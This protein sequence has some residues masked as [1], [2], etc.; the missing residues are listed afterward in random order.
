MTLIELIYADISKQLVEAV[1]K[2]YK[3]GL[4]EVVKLNKKKILKLAEPSPLFKISYTKADKDLLANFEKEAFTVAAVLHFECEEKLKKIAKEILS[5]EHPYLQAHP[6]SSIYDLWADEAY[7]IL[8]DYIEVADAPP[9]S[10]LTTNLRTAINSSFFA[11]EYNRLQ[12]LKDVYPY[13]QYKTQD[14]SL[15]REEHRVLHDK[16][17]AAS[18]PAWDVIMP[19][20]GWNCRCYFT[21]LTYEEAGEVPKENKI[22]ILDKDKRETLINKANIPEEFKRNAAKQESIW[23]KWLN[24]KLT[25]KDWKKINEFVKDNE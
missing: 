5:G 11:A 1:N 19:I 23:G 24:E 3:K 20:N 8:A 16:V 9:P 4:Q 7:N 21:P 18:D 10:Q 25:D 6:E 14:D 17:F 13:Y 22:D 2:G 12:E 15:V